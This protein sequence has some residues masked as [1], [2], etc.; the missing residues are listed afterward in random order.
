[1]IQELFKQHADQYISLY[2]PPGEHIKVIRSIKNCRSGNY[3]YHILSCPDCGEIKIL[4]NSCRNR[5]CPVCQHNAREAWLNNRKD[6]LLDVPY[7]HLVFTLPHI[8][9]PIAYKYKTIV[10]DVLFKAVNRTVEIF[11][12][13]PKWLGAQAGAI[14][15]LHTWGQNLTFHPHIHLVMPA[16]GL[17][18]DT[19]EWINTHPRFFAPV[20]ALSIVFKEI[21]LKKL[22][23]EFQKQK[24]EYDKNSLN[25]AQ[26]KNWVVFAQ[27]PFNK[28]EHVINYLGNYTHRVA[29]SNYRIIKVENGQVYFWYK[30]YRKN[31]SRKIMVLTEIE[32]MRRFLQHVLPDNFYKIRYFG[33]LSN[34]FRR[35][36]IFTARCAIA[37][38]QGKDF[39]DNRFENKLSEFIDKITSNPYPCPVCGGKM[40]C[41]PVF[42]EPVTNLP[43]PET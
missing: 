6:E 18:K 29:I 19:G 25:A 5:H 31:G 30:D 41:I 7:F 33:F 2:K 10:F 8:L 39:T 11:A 28:P 40:L 26:R 42:N 4:N 43:L 23:S 27:K 21:F 35:E 38:D 20:K 24:I 9:N 36:N 12:E 15:I 34:R 1:M 37:Q 3:G 17:V 14:A 16:G 13:D 32:F 22:R